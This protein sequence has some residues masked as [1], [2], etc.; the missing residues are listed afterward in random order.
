MRPIISTLLIVITLP[1]GMSAQCL[2]NNNFLGESCPVVNSPDGCPTWNGSCVGWTKSHGTPDI[3]QVQL[4]NYK[5]SSYNIVF[6]WGAATQGEGMFTSYTFQA[7]STYDVRLDFSSTCT[8]TGHVNIYAMN[9]LT[10]HALTGCGNGY[11][12]PSGGQLIG[13]YTGNTNGAIT[14]VTYTF[15][16]NNNYDQLW[17]FPDGAG[18]EGPSEYMMTFFDVYAC[19]SCSNLI[20]YNTGTVPTST[21]TAGNFEVGSSAGSGGSG[22]VVNAS[23][24]STVLIARQQIQ[25][26]Q[27]FTATPS[28]TGSFIA[29]I[30]PC[31]PAN[32][33]Q[34]ESYAID[35]ATIV[36]PPQPESAKTGTAIIGHGAAFSDPSAVKLQIYPTISNG[37]FTISGSA[38]DLENANIVVADESGQPVYR[39]HNGTATTLNLNLGNLGSGIYF[40]QI[41][42]QSGSYIQKIIVTR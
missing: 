30:S 4:G 42:N 10:E 18:S 38:A 36:D 1:L 20:I 24:Q 41:S 31:D 9:G 29:E 16:A 23:G 40:L 14:D 15:T 2:T 17:I 35:S 33:V 22:T 39:L 19:P 8:T 28:G 5:L 12:S 21:T 32:T 3:I 34:G 37:A 27:N 13:Q 25:L 6:M 26:L 7:G 11:P